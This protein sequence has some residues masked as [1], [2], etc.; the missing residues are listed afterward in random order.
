LNAT[1]PL[2]AENGGRNL[3]PLA[4]TY[5]T[6]WGEPRT[7]NIIKTLQKWK[8]D[9]RVIGVGSPWKGF[10]SKANGFMKE[11][12]RMLFTEPKRIVVY[13]DASDVVA[14]GSPEQFKR[15]FEAASRARKET[16][17][18]GKSVAIENVM[19]ASSE[20][21][22][23]VEPMFIH[24]PGTF[25]DA[26]D[27][28]DPDRR[29][30]HPCKREDMKQDIADKWINELKKI[31]RLYVGDSENPFFVLNAGMFAGRA[32]DIVRIIKRVNME[33]R[34]DDQAMLTEYYLKAHGSQMLIDYDNLL[35]SNSN[36]LHAKF[37]PKDDRANGCFFTWNE[38][39]RQWTNDITNTR[40]VFIQTPAGYWGCYDKLTWKSVPSSAS[41]VSPSWVFASLVALA[42]SLFG[43]A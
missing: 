32:E 22:C 3:P 23:C 9:F 7:N 12:E 15:E 1:T 27:L 28:R 35:F 18:D 34:E 25:L 8:W 5:Q 10:G 42:L 38:G 26:N 13:I 39:T 4:I 17:I 43:N 30:L 33:D 29:P 16:I 19:M 11:V 36:P 41:C 40:P 6:K 14:N 37:R 24:S 20:I 21:N 31:Q 2:P